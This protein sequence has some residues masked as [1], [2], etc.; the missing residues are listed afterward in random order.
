MTEDELI[1]E[2]AVLGAA[3]LGTRGHD[4]ILS[5]QPEDFVNPKHGIIAGALKAMILRGEK[6]DEITL[7][8]ELAGRSQLYGPGS[9][10][11]NT[12]INSLAEA[13]AVPENGWHYAVIV[14]EATRVRMA[15]NAATSL[16]QSMAAQGAAEHMDELLA[17][18]TQAMQA[19]PSP[20][21]QDN[22]EIPTIADLFDQKFEHRWLIPGL[23][24]RRERV[25]LTAFEGT[26]K[27]VSLST[28]ACALA[29]GLHPYTGESI[30]AGMRV[31]LVD[32]END[33]E[34][35]QHRFRW[36]GERIN[37]LGG[38]PGWAKRIYQQIRPE[39]L[40]LSGKDRE[41]FKR[42]V[43]NTAPD[44]IVMGP[45]YK[46]MGAAKTSDDA[47]IL[48]WFAAMDEVRVKH[49][50]ALI[51]EAHSGHAKDED[52]SR[53]VRPFGSSVWL[54]WPQVGIGLKRNKELDPGKEHPE[55]VDVVHWRGS[56][57]VRDWPDLL[58][59]GRENQMPWTPMR[60]DYGR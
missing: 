42:V 40:D 49:D 16:A 29:A 43:S 25:V 27:S 23:L 58:K 24:H 45:A 33:E 26:G 10:G 19:I 4:G 11:G 55:V 7:C 57:G 60:D 54:R 44:L 21:D 35:T 31:L 46:L 50:V 41:W 8:A 14:R 34:E 52:G 47:A 20:L 28:W 3:M 59:R 13:V 36:I 17:R 30:G 18:H 22:V 38:E 53:S 9:A 32:T 1:P 2:Q 12:Y 6:P 48:A 15:K 56:R 51:I 39:G 5:L 37:A